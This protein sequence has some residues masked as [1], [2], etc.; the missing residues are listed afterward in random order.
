[1]D[2]KIWKTNCT[3]WKKKPLAS[4][5]LWNFFDQKINIGTQTNFDSCIL[6]IKLITFD[7]KLGL[8][9]DTD[10]IL[11]NQLFQKLKLSKYIIHTF[12]KCSYWEKKSDMFRWF[13]TLK[14][15]FWQ[16]VVYCTYSQDV[17]IFFEY[18]K[19]CQQSLLI[20]IK[21]L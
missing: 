11:E 8:I 21:V 9:L 13:L 1:M 10:L 2:L 7:Q 3:F 6:W 4:V 18:A 5:W 15:R 16:T 20:I 14:V 12:K 17:M 19:V